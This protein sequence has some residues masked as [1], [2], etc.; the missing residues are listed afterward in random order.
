MIFG[1]IISCGPGVLFALEESLS[2][3][4]CICEVSFGMLMGKL[5]YT[6]WLGM[7]GVNGVYTDHW[8]WCLRL[9]FFKQTE[10]QKSRT[11]I[12]A[13]AFPVNFYRRLYSWFC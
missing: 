10:G 4:C 11:V 12:L 1:E 8:V 5:I 6:R 2:S 7:L 13:Q 3:T 9:D